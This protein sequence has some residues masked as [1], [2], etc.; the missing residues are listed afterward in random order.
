MEGS[1]FASICVIVFLLGLSLLSCQTGIPKDALLL[2]PESLKDRQLQTR[3]FDTADEEMLLA[4]SAAVL[5]DTGYTIEESEV[6][7]GVIVASRDRDVAEIGGQ[8]GWV[9]LNVPYAQRQKVFASLVTKLLPATLLMF[10]G[11][12]LRQVIASAFILAAPLTLLV[13]ASEMGHELGVLDDRLS[14]AIVLLAIAS[15]VVF[16]TAFKVLVPKHPEESPRSDETIEG[17]TGPDD[18]DSMPGLFG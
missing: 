10:A 14:E 7:L 11:I 13:A 6:P 18:E 8:I 5:Q 3:I 9:C 4:A 12:S 15:G 1:R 16:P 17:L 2:S